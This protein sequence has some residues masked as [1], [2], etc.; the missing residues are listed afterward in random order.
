MAAVLRSADFAP[1]RLQMLR[2]VPISPHLSKVRNIEIIY[3]RSASLYPPYGLRDDRVIPSVRRDRA[4]IDPWHCPVAVASALPIPIPTQIIVSMLYENPVNLIV[5]LIS[6][7]RTSPVMRRREA[8]EE[9]KA[10]IEL[11]VI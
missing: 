4:V 9:E 5:C 1:R 3:I 11:H 2:N 7:C 10:L 8:P 6:C